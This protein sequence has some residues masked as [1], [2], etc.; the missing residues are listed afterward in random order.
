MRTFRV[1]LGSPA[2]CR[3]LEELSV[4]KAQQRFARAVRFVA[5][6]HR[7]TPPVTVSPLEPGQVLLANPGHGQ[8]PDI[9]FLLPTPP[10]QG[11]P[12]DVFTLGQIGRH[13]LGI[14]SGLGDL[15]TECMAPDP[16]DRPADAGAV[17]QHARSRRSGYVACCRGSSR[18][19]AARPRPICAR[20]RRTETRHRV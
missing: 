12:A 2:A 16:L 9:R 4:E 18:D 5:E 7:R 15:L 8:E 1:D 14:D 20:A 13:L 11:D 19:S 17:L 3:R 6:L 10:V